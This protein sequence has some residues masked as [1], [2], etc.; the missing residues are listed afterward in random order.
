MTTVTLQ[1]AD[2]P[3]VVSKIICVGRN[4][5]KHAKE[6]K[7]D[8]PTVPMLFLKPPSAVIHNH[9]H[10]VIPA[11]S[12]ELHHE[13]EMT[14]LI[15]TGG[16]TISKDKAMSHIAGYGIG[17]D[18]TL[19][20]VQSEAKAKG[21]PWSVA[22]GF[23]TSA[24]LSEFVPASAVPD[25]H[26]LGVELTVNGTVRQ[27]GSTKD[28]I[29]RLD[30]LLSYASQFFTLEP[31]DVI[32]TGTPEGVGQAVS[33]DTLLARLLGHDGKPITTVMAHVQ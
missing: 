22:K 3:F 30:H 23:N 5:A 28:F 11:I 17:L 26:V 4:Y 18:M 33:G 13:V 24:P 2:K 12:K 25:P 20:D 15:G 27:S 1:G 10:I 32:F 29:F 9:G 16:S 8:I 14:V 7:S 21:H 19:R 6:M 31:G